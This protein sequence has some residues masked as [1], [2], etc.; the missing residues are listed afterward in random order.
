LSQESI[1]EILTKYKTIAVVGLSRE[2][3]K[4]SYEVGAY[5]KKHGFR[6]VPVN[7]FANEI[8]GEKCYKS[9]LDMPTAVQ[10]AVEVVD[11]F[12]RPEDIPPIA[13]QAVKLKKM[14]GTL[15]VF[16]MQLGLV[17][18]RAAGTL[19]EGGL[20]V[21]MDKCLMQEHKSVVKA[22]KGKV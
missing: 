21:I 13:E 16:W 20:T 4:E 11:V 6:I 10:K 15:R 2:P 5:L 17:N 7:P 12:R 1:E 8:L 22:E 19:R 9:L 3:E 18:E 14:Y